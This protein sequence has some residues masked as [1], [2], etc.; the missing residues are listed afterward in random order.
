MDIKTIKAGGILVKSDFGMYTKD[1]EIVLLSVYGALQQVKAVFA[2]IAAFK[3]LTVIPDGINVQRSNSSLRAL[4][5][6]IGYG[7]RHLLIWASDA[8][9]RS[10]IWMNGDEDKE[11]AVE[12]FLSQRKV[13]YERDFFLPFEKSLLGEELM[14]PMAGWGG[15]CGYAVNEEDDGRLCDIMLDIAASAVDN[16]LHCVEG[17]MTG[18]GVLQGCAS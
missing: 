18:E 8:A 3:S 9:D 2:A 6:S 14:E 13:P 17:N 5:R 4:G 10:I 15:V 16:G 11:A 1:N 12:A 7:K